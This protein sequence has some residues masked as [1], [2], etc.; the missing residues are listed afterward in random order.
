M[1]YLWIFFMSEGFVKKINMLSLFKLGLNQLGENQL[2]VR[3][4]IWLYIGRNVVEGKDI[5]VM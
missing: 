1:V 5:V 3:R 4:Y 2:R